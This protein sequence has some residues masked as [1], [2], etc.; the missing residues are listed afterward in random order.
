MLK[1][2]PSP[3][4]P[5]AS[6]FPSKFY[7][8]IKSRTELYRQWP[9]NWR[10]KARPIE[11]VGLLIKPARSSS[12]VAKPVREGEI[13]GVKDVVEIGVSFHLEALAKA[14]GLQDAEINVEVTSASSFEVAA[15]GGDKTF[16]HVVN[17]RLYAT[18]RIQ[19]CE[20]RTVA[21]SRED[22]RGTGGGADSIV[23]S[24]A[25]T[26]NIQPKIY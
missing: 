19:G 8:K 7:L 3:T 6:K 13:F 20:R 11:C 21:T 15:A 1:K 16:T 18:R 5:G 17:S 9:S 4:G 12:R 26:I 22:C 2:A 25:V 23:G 14:K 10:T 24:Q